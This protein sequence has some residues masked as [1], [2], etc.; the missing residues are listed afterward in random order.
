M[1]EEVKRTVLVDAKRIDVAMA[2]VGVKSDEEL[3]RLA[4]VTSQTIRNIRNTNSCSLRVLSDVASALDINPI[5]LLVTP[6]YPDPKAGA[7]VAS[8]A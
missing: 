7:L 2:I 8:L 4:D 6:G 1:S 3:A 5:D